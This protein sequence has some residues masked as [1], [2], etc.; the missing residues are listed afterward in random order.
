ML[1]YDRHYDI[2]TALSTIFVAL[3]DGQ[4]MP[5][6]TTTSKK[7]VDKWTVSRNHK[8]ILP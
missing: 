2:I 7:L 6:T 5:K 1:M 4:L 3:H 8:L